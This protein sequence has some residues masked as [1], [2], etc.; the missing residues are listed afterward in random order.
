M[1]FDREAA[2]RSREYEE[3]LDIQRELERKLAELK[4]EARSAKSRLLAAT[5]KSEP[6]HKFTLGSLDRDAKYAGEQ[7]SARLYVRSLSWED[8]CPLM[9]GMAA[10]MPAGTRNIDIEYALVCEHE[11]SWSSM[12]DA[13]LLQRAKVAY[14]ADVASFRK[15]ERENP[16]SDGWR[17]KPATRGQGFLIARMAQTLGID[18][19]TRLNRGDA[20]DWI[21]DHGGN[22]RLASD[23]PLQNMPNGSPGEEDKSGDGDDANPGISS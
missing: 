21:T 11:E 20:H 5:T 8:Y 9:A 22:L 2:R 3:K 4:R 18:P 13:L 12:G 6:W 19:P 23:A 7:A 10:R 14:T 1:D 16:D 15:W 17:R